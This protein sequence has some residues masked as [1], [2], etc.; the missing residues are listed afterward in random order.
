MAGSWNRLSPRARRALIT[1]GAAET[2]LKIAALAD[3][4]RRPAAQVRGSKKTWA[5][6]IA[7]TNSAG[8]VPFAYF[9]RGRRD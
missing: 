3:L 9:L 1:V 2:A 7:L 4:R 6:A 5:L 8:A